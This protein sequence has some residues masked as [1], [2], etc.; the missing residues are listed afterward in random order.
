MKYK[1]IPFYLGSSKEMVS[2]SQ[3]CKWGLYTR[4]T[5]GIL[6]LSWG[7]SER[8][9]RFVISSRSSTVTYKCGTCP[10]DLGMQI[11][12]EIGLQAN[13]AI[14]VNLKP[15]KKYKWPKYYGVWHAISQL[16]PFCL[17]FLINK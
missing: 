9:Y 11:K 17:G 7:I 10:G 1:N 3:L 2:L 6:N 8:K 16:M 12:K 15:C 14:K 13:R 4:K 5:I